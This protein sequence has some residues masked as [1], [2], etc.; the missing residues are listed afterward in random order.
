MPLKILTDTQVSEFV[1]GLDLAEGSEAHRTLNAMMILPGAAF[2]RAISAI[3]QGLLDFA[4]MRSLPAMNERL[5]DALIASRLGSG[6][7]SSL[8]W[9]Y[10]E[11]WLPA[12]IDVVRLRRRAIGDP[13]AAIAARF[14]DSWGGIIRPNYDFLRT[15]ETKFHSY[16]EAYVGY[17]VIANNALPTSV[18]QQFLEYHDASPVA[19]AEDAPIRELIASLLVEA[20][21]LERQIGGRRP[22]PLLD[23]IVGGSWRTVT[24]GNFNRF[25][26]EIAYPTMAESDD[27]ERSGRPAVE[28][29]LA[30]DWPVLGSTEDPSWALD[31]ARMAKVY[32]PE[33]YDIDVDDARREDAA[34]TAYLEKARTAILDFHAYVARGMANSAISYRAIG[35]SPMGL[36]LCITSA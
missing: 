13:A 29:L 28:S 22:Y 1:S 25:M 15:D 2:T 9:R 17:M 10:R 3:A 36:L 5:V 27:P 32:L 6:D 12:S 26:A 11:E 4:A 24:P 21:F 23:W 8:A 20:T 7:V 30:A 18:V 14:I 33:A 19:E 16:A 35:G 34:F 31:R